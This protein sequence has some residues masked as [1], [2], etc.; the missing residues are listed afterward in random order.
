YTGTAVM[1]G[2][3]ALALAL[4]E[5]RLPTAAGVLTPATGIGT[6]LVERLRTHRFTVET[7]GVEGAAGR[8]V[9]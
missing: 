5:D 7:S 4:D 3:S 6:P 9:R 8:H 2:Q 1:F